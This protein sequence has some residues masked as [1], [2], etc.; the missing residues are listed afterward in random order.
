MTLPQKFKAEHGLFSAMKRRCRKHP[1]YLLAGIGYDPAFDGPGGF[2][3]FLG[4]VGPKPGVGFS[5]DRIDNA[6]GYMADNL[7]WATASQ[8]ANNTSRTLFFTVNGT[9][10]SL[11]EWAAL[12]GLALGTLYRRVVLRG[13]PLAEALYPVPQ[14]SGGATRKAANLHKK[15]AN[16]LAAAIQRCCNPKNYSFSSYGARGITVADA[17]RG[18]GGVQRFI[19]HIGPVPTDGQVYSLDRIDT[20]GNYCPG[21]VRWATSLT[22]NNNRV[23]SVYVTLPS[24]GE[25]KTVA[26]WGRLLTKTG[27]SGGGALR[28]GVNISHRLK[29]GWDI[30]RALTTPTSAPEARRWG[31]LI[32]N[33]TGISH[34]ASVWATMA[35]VSLL[36][37]RARLNSGWTIDAAVALPRGV[38]R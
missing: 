23:T 27:G 35:G 17:W 24:T 13:R 10:R 18:K 11:A 21:N 38:R 28:G 3:A 26:E 22:Q 6:R 4:A 5:L 9:T 34:P 32:T 2:A 12:H 29:A 31:R 19:A 37:L 25:T 30:D 36:C 14:K 15:E 7:R 8:Q 16:A 1:R 20:R 33:A